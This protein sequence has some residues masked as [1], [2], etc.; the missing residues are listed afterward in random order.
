MSLGSR[1]IAQWGDLALEWGYSKPASETTFFLKL[2][3]I[4]GGSKKVAAV[5]CLDTSLS[6]QN[7]GKIEAAKSAVLSLFNM[8][9]L[10]T[11]RALMLKYAQSAV[12]ST[13]KAMSKIL[14]EITEIAHYD[15]HA[16]SLLI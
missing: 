5:I 4:R 8:G 2:R 15:A 6:M 3:P 12:Q 16:V 1:E 10:F 9:E 13:G 11:E 14:L 7:Y